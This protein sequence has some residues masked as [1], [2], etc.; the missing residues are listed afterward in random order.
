VKAKMRSG[1]QGLKS[2]ALGLGILLLSLVVGKA[3]A[4]NVRVGIASLNVTMMPLAVAR[5]Q[6]FFQQEGLNVDLVVMPAALNIKVLLS[7]DIDY[8]TTVGS[9]VIAAVRGID[10]RVVMLFTDRPLFDL[11]ATPKINSVA[12]LKGR[13]ISI[14]SR[15]G[16][17]DAILR[18]ML[19]QSGVDQ[20]EVSVLTIA[21]PSA[22]VAAI[23]SERIAA[24]LIIPPYNFLAYREGLK[25]LGSAGSFMRLPSAGIVAMREKLDRNPDQIRRMLRALTRAQAF[26]K[27]QKLAV[28]PILKRFMGMKDEDLLSQIYDYHRRAEATDGRIDT[29]LAAETIRD[30][31]VSE[32]VA[33]E[34]PVEQVF[35]FS[36]LTQ[37]R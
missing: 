28:I 37:R 26:A 13:T 4:E 23:K 25:N 1:L 12:E 18:R 34:I 17:Q 15:G 22:M 24:G 21:I 32:G 16:I 5:E 36:Y 33:K 11:V 35:D 30:T 29:A 20:R 27:E 2:L 9:A 19:Q 8:A 10:V 31:R 7:G 3:S 6:G 14:S